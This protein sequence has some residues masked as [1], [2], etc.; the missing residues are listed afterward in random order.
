MNVKQCPH[1]H[2]YDA[3]RFGNVCPQCAAG[4][5]NTGDA[6]MA[7]RSSGMPGSYDATVPLNPNQGFVSGEDPTVPVQQVAPAPAPAPEP[8]PT[9]V[10]ISEPDDEKTIGMKLWSIGK[11]EE[12]EKVV[13]PEVSPVVGWLVCIQGNNIG[14]DY[15]LVAGRNFVGR[16]EEMD[17]CIK[18]DNSVSRSSHAI[19]VYDPKSNMFLAQPG[20]AKELFYINGDLVLSATKLNP[21]DRMSIGDTVLLFQPLCSSDFDWSGAGK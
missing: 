9:P 15:R 11:E 8:A 6:T 5:G 21:L 17:V 10:P 7:L 4:N 13:E 14:R 16:A 20:D 1:G 19:V 18:G 3:D 2:Y 12:E